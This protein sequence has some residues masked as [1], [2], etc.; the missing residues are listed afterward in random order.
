MDDIPFLELD[1]RNLREGHPKRGRETRQGSFDLD[2]MLS[3]ARDLKYTGLIRKTLEKQ[4]DAPNEEL[5]RLSFNAAS[6]GGRFGKNA[7]E[8]FAPLVK[9]ALSEAITDRVNL[10]L[11]SPDAD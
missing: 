4:F 1:L 3:A 5:T 6:P 2:D 7:R 9:K 8:Q 10:R 11:R